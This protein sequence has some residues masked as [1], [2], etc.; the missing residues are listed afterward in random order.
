MTVGWER[1]AC[2][3]VKDSRPY[4]WKSKIL[5]PFCGEGDLAKT[6]T[7]SPSTNH[8]TNTFEPKNTPPRQTRGEEREECHR[9]PGTTALSCVGALLTRDYWL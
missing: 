2:D 4:A 9:V 1:H 3:P 7:L 6:R 8:K 5:G